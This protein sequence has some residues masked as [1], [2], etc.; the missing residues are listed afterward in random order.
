MQQERHAEQV[1]VIDSD[2][3]IKSKTIYESEITPIY[4]ID[5]IQKCAQAIDRDTQ[6]WRHG[7]GGPDVLE[8]LYAHHKYSYDSREIT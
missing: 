1:K 4:S 6:V 7:M 8:G 3:L 2:Y 5:D